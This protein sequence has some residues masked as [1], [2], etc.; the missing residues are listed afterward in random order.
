MRWAR[1]FTL[2][3][4]LAPAAPAW[5][6][7]TLVE[8]ESGSLAMGGY[9]R[10]LA[11]IQKLSLELAP[12]VPSNLFPNHFS[13]SSTVLRLEWKAALGDHFSAEVHQRVFLRLIS[14]T[15]VFG[16]EKVGLGASVVPSRTV[17]LRSVAYDEDRLLLEH[18]IDRLALRA[19][20]GDFDVT[21]GRQA[22]TWGIAELF[23]VA[24]LWT[25][26]SP[27]EVDTT[28]KRGIDA[29]RVLYARE[30]SLEIEAVLADRG[31]L[32][33][34]S[35]GLRVATY[36]PGADFYFA[37]AK[38]WRELLA[39]A[40]VSATAGAFKL[41][42]EA[43]EP[44]DLDGRRR[45]LSPPRASLG[46]DWLHPSLTL[47]LEGHYNGT[48][49]LRASEYLA[50]YQSS[51]ALKRG[52]SYLL[53]RWYAGAS[54]IW[55]I[56]E[57]FQLSLVALCN[58]QDPSWLLAGAWTYQVTQGTEL[59]LGMYQGIGKNPLIKLKSELRSELGSA[60]GMYYLA[61]SSFF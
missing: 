36:G 52:E 22:I 59:S 25:N 42:V 19:S 43:A 54:A 61:L 56:S 34:L 53:G 23:P 50:H 15:L 3:A 12:G 45:E 49:V 40:G 47:S 35:G 20:L 33:D 1:A 18:D 27:F 58:L 29:L 14:E 6:A 28:Q 16:G 13:Q 57:L 5:G 48:G 31:A 24:D 37:L 2:L 26:F 17:N 10:T 4:L 41:R 60:G 46:V 51:P 55:K 11:G 30:R 8:G 38:Q 39:F 21:L 44:F 9:A 32:R 7:L